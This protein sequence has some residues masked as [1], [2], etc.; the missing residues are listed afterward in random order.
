[1]DGVSG[2]VF[3]FAEIEPSSPIESPSLMGR[4]APREILRSSVAIDATV[5]VTAGTGT[6]SSV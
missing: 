2:G 6:L 1:M 3:I 4:T 5:S